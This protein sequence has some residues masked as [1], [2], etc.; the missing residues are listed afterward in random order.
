M[1]K[2]LKRSKTAKSNSRSSRNDTSINQPTVREQQA[3][4]SQICD[5]RLK[6]RRRASNLRT[7]TGA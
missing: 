3:L 7:T 1:G 4:R 5:P 6:F 2:S